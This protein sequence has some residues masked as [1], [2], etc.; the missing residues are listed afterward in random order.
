MKTKV[1]SDPTVSF[2]LLYKFTT[3][4]SMNQQLTLPIMFA[5]AGAV[6]LAAWQRPPEAVSVP[7]ESAVMVVD[8]V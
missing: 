8:M 7:A 4:S 3:T 6:L 1:I 2:F 5:G